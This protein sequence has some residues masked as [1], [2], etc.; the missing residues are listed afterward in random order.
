MVPHVANNCVLTFD[1]A[2]PFLDGGVNVGL[3]QR[4]AHG[5]RLR[6]GF[7][8]RKSRGRFNTLCFVDFMDLFRFGEEQV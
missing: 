2:V 5:F 7:G 8:Y 6:S 4:P 3:G 1:F